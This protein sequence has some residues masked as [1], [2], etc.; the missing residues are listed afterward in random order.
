MPMSPVIGYTQFFSNA[1]REQLALRS[2][3][4][5]STILNLRVDSRFLSAFLA[6]ALRSK[7]PPLGNGMSHVR[8]PD[9]LLF[10]SIVKV[11]SY[12]IADVLFEFSPW[13]LT[14]R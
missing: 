13:S 14:A 3:S 10:S 2:S 8:A 4:N 5:E 1:S 6:F 9:A 11:N 12:A 7:L